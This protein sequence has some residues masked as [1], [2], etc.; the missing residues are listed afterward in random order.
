MAAIPEGSVVEKQEKEEE[1]S[2]EQA[3]GQVAEQSSR[4][5]SH[6]LGPTQS[7]PRGRPKR[8]SL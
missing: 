2:G 6:Q 5:L 8:R 4:R 3:G 7:M 1:T